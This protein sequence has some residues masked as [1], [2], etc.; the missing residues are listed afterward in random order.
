[1]DLER[2]LALLGDMARA[3]KG[4]ATIVARHPKFV[5]GA[6]AAPLPDHAGVVGRLADRLRYQP[7]DEAL[8]RALVGDA[9]VVD[10]GATA[11]ALVA[12]GAATGV[13][14]TLEGTVFL[15]DGSVRGGA[16]DAANAHLVEQRREM[17][18]LHE[19]VAVQGDEVTTL[20]EAQS[21]LR[22]R[23]AEV[24]VALDRARNEAHQGELA[25]VTAQK[26]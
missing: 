23:L 21:A 11:A 4:R 15:P 22:T 9:L 18:E 8:V 2:G 24:T 7:E 13:V 1:D 17:R 19:I 25:L 14:V 16:G 5:A 26:D 20:L 3:S 6:S 10:T 12:S